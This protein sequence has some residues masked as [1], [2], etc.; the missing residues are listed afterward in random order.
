MQTLMT[1][2]T[3]LDPDGSGV[4]Q[5]SEMQDAMSGENAEAQAAM[6]DLMFPP[7]FDG[8]EL[9][10]CFGGET[11]EVEVSQFRKNAVR[12]VS[13][14]ESVFEWHCLLMLKL[15]QILL[16]VQGIDN[17]LQKCELHADSRNGGPP[18]KPSTEHLKTRH[19]SRSTS[20]SA[21]TP[22]T[23][24]TALDRSKTDASGRSFTSI[25]PKDV[26]S[27]GACSEISVVSLEDAADAVVEA[28]RNA[29]EVLTQELQKEAMEQ[30]QRMCDS[31]EVSWERVK[32]TAQKEVRDK[33]SQLRH[34][35]EQVFIKAQP[36]ETITV[37][38][39]FQVDGV[40]KGMAA[41][42]ELPGTRQV[43][44]PCHEEANDPQVVPMQRASSPKQH[45]P[46]SA[47]C[48]PNHEL[49]V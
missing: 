7:G 21:A 26:L 9:L 28:L 44:I 8:S 47:N 23:K 35:S 29:S 27:P 25:L 38:E 46:G 31:L 42:I 12:V 5:A 16:R 32:R 17:R 3:S 37:G 1:L 48:E 4:I 39:R 49:L 43:H 20:D 33:I 36:A 14:T 30:H 41:D 19:S 2:T 22:C 15:N 24:A 11:D 45:L 13:S 40:V 6:K 34:R 18:H 10:A